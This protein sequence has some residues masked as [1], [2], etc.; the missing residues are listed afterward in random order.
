MGARKGSMEHL[1][2]LLAAAD[3]NRKSLSLSGMSHLTG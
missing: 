1:N 2:A 3:D